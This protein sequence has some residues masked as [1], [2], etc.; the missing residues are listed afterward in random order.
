MNSTLTIG[1]FTLESLT[2]G[3]YASPKDLFREYIQ[4][5]A[6]SIDEAVL[7]GIMVPN[8]NNI[9]ISI[10]KNLRQIIFEDNGTGIGIDHALKRLTDIGN[11]SKSYTRSRGFRGIGRLAGLSYCDKLTFITSCVGESYK[12]TIVF[13]AAKLKQLLI[14]GEYDDYDLLDVV[15]EITSYEKTQEQSKK[16]YF[17]VVLDKVTDI[18]GLLDIEQMRIYLSQTAPVPFDIVLFKWGNE[19]KKKIALHN[20]KISEYNIYIGT[21]DMQTQ[22][23]K[24]YTDDIIADKSR[25]IRNSINDITIREIYNEQNNLQ[26]IMWYGETEFNGT[27]L[28]D[29]KKGI[30]LRKGNMLVGDKNTVSQLFKEERFNGW[31]C[32]E[33]YIFDEQ[34]IPNARR[35]N[36][37]QNGAFVLFTTKL[38]NICLALSQNI[39]QISA[40]RVKLRECFLR[41][42]ILGIDDIKQDVILQDKDELFDD[43]YEVDNFVE[44]DETQVDITFDDNLF[45]KIDSLVKNSDTLTKYQV[46]NLSRKLTVDQKKSLEKVFNIISNNCRKKASED[47]INKIIANF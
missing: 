8:D 35:D 36:F 38:T 20:I 43:L 31:F 14:P 17:K 2:T 44:D 10:D 23:F 32:G 27:I 29:G 9:K 16:H 21:A 19:V 6:D 15:S 12:S 4:N 22:I 1:K 40:E 37:E 33:I 25:K 3:M 26:A 41:D 45:R 11:S 39:R 7:Q 24:P 46:L 47:L 13:D 28:D 34:L 42:N 5:G 18:D 30:R